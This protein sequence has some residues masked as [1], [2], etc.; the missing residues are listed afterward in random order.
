M[1]QIAPESTVSITARRGGEPASL[2]PG[3]EA[4]PKASA[5]WPWLLALMLLTA[6][7]RA[8][9][10]NQQ[11][12]YDEIVTVVNSVRKPLATILTTY[13]TQNQHTLYS[14]LAR[15]SMIL[16]GEQPWVLRL[17]ALLFG[18][19]SVPALYFFARLVTKRREALLASALMAVSYHHVWFSQNARGYTAML[20]WTLLATYFFV[21][22]A[23]GSGWGAWTGYGLAMALG[24]YTHLTVGFVAAGHGLVYL[25][26]MGDQRRELRRWP[27]NSL[28]PLAGFAFAGLVTLALYAP[29]LPQLFAKTVGQTGPAIHWEWKNPLWL[30]LETWR[31]LVAGA[32][33]TWVAVAIAGVFALAGLVSY[34]R[35]DH[36]MVGLMILPAVLTIVA[37]LTLEH[38][39]WPRFFF[40]AI[41]FAI[42]LFVRGAMVWG[43]VAARW[44]RSDPD[45]GLRWGT[46]LVGLAL[47]GSVWSLRTDYGYPKQDFIGA[48]RL[49][50]ANRQ[51]G[52]PVVTVGLTSFAYQRYFGRDWR[53]VESYAELESVRSQDHRTWLVYIFPIYLKTR[54]PEIWKAI[55]TEFTTVGVFPGTLG[56]GEIYVCQAAARHDAPVAPR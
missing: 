39:L 33:G 43:G 9:G 10:L 50:D 45:A 23:Q 15:A 35:Q 38:N 47:A 56:D 3:L 51:Q 30:V 29:L 40:F 17:P 25:W 54:Y 28:R 6:V 26:L 37:M 8:I 52:E 4:A 20:F 44:L 24:M 32:G 12:W 27:R 18:V 7:L 36:Y 21:R 2:W 41:G 11:L 14:V 53:A 48:M 1:L 13:T 49:V 5:P 34:W 55:Q 46:A 31:G 22:G 19:A 16:L 42:L